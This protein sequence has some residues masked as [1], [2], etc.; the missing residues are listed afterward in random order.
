ML[1]YTFAVVVLLLAISYS[2]ARIVYQL[3]LHP[4]SHVPGPR[5]AALSQ[6]YEFYYH[7]L[8]GGAWERQIR[9]I[10]ENYSS[11]IVRIGPNEVHINDP[12]YYDTIFS[13]N[14]KLDKKKYAVDNLQHTPSHAQHKLRRYGLESFFSRGSIINLEWVVRDNVEKL[15]TQLSAARDSST[16]INLSYL[17]RCFTIDFITEYCFDRNYRF[18][19]DPETAK[20]FLDAITDAEKTTYVKRTFKLWH[21]MNI[22]LAFTS[23]RSILPRNN[24]IGAFIRVLQTI[25][26]DVREAVTKDAK[27][28]G[29]RTVFTELP[30]NEKLPRSEKTEEI[31]F[32]T[33]F[34]LLVAG[35]ETTAHTLETA[36]FH[37]NVPK[38][39]PMLM[40]LKDEV[41]AIWPNVEGE[42][43]DWKT[44]EKLPYLQAVLKESLRLSL[45]VVGRLTRINHHEAMVYKEWAI[46]AGS[47]ISMT[48]FDLHFNEDIFPDPWE[49]KPDR[50]LGAEGKSREKYLVSFSRGS[51]ACIGVNLAMC[52]LH[53]ALATIVRRF[54]LRLFETDR[55]AVDYKYDYFIPLPETDRGVRVEVL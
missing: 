24:R 4:I 44:L 51:R 18:L 46:P 2:A 3:Y 32:N 53:I 23:P 43:P 31:I 6:L 40:R 29:R 36:S 17:Y 21:S 28:G 49:F 55:R 42:V 52:E 34:L 10:H 7:I 54:D 25:R 14:P 16:P 33:A 47:E 45:G 27:P 11:P 12:E 15:C 13:F 19:E 50:W 22:W 26:K 48:Q 35:F 39:L 38:G 41:A 30:K 1:A 5:L 20:P 9:F 37:L 8:V